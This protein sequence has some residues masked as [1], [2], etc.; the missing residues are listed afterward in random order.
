MLVVSGILLLS[1][2]MLWSA[3]FIQNPSFES[4]YNEDFPHY[5]PVDSWVGGSGVN[6]DAGPFH[7]TGTPIPDRSRVGFKQ[8]SGDLSQDIAG[9]TA[10]KQYWIQFF[11]DARNCCGGTIDIVTKFP[12]A[13]TVLDRIAN[14]RPAILS[15]KP[16]YARSVPFVAASDSGT[17]TFTTTASGDATALFDGVTIVERDTN[18]IVV[19]NP[20]FEASGTLPALGQIASVAGW[21]GAGTFGVDA[22]AGGAGFA[23]N[24]AVPDQDLVAFIQ[25]PGSLG[26]TVA[27]LAV[28]KTYQVTVAYNAKSGTVPHF[29]IKVDDAVLFEEDVS[30]VGAANPYKL[31]T[32]SFVA[33]NILAQVAFEQTKDGADVLLL[34]DVRVVGEVQKPLPPLAID[35]N[36]TELAPGQKA[37]VTVTVPTELLA[38]KSATI[39]FQSPNPAVAMLVNADADGFVA[40]QYAQGGTNVQSFDVEAVGRGTVR[41]VVVDS[42]G[43]TV[44]NDVTVN[45]VT[46]FVR[47]PSFESSPAPA[48]LGYGS[49]LAWTTPASGAGLNTVAGPF[50]DNGVIPDRKQVAF[51]QN[52]GTISQ[53]IFGLSPGKKYWLQFYYNARNC[54][55]GTNGLTVRFDGKNLVTVPQITPV[56]EQNSYYF[57]HLELSPTNATGLLE[58]VATA[59]GDATLLLDA[60]TIVQRDAGEIVIKNPSFEAS[61][62]PAN[63]GY[64]QPDNIA[65]WDAGGVGRG[66]NINGAG[67]FTDNGLAS[68]QDLV[69]FLQGKTTLVSQNITGLNA[70]Q[71]YTLI[72]DVNARNCCVVEPSS[73]RASFD[74]TPLVEEEITPVG[75]GAPFITR[76][77]L[78]KPTASEGVLKFENTT[79]SG[80]HT[81]LLDNVRIVPGVIVPAP[82]LTPQVA[83]GNTIRI[84]WPTAATQFKLQTTASLP[85]NWTDVT[86]QIV[87]EGNDNVV[88][89]SVGT[90]GNKFYRLIGTP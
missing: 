37:T 22:A 54:C 46:A 16:Y 23:N 56:L 33:S 28:G 7:N 30:P 13:D 42:A 44:V 78:F 47:N 89:E 43:L 27:N 3:S 32:V 29:R 39:T 73:Y 81:I 60:I 88:T 55:G 61:G 9:L 5:G 48:G 4:N 90:T 51:I 12:D 34:D 86:T 74:D 77:V 80:D 2:S 67:P 17:L 83:A 6:E 57:Q 65:G 71:Q 69:L 68:D 40:L 18:N 36:F 26:Q 38:T 84:A 70:G 35:P 45:V 62:T 21:T 72:F 66:V 24:G 53:Q 79:A 87:V 25:G 11:Y 85:G 15:S 75:A 52:S 20:S 8:G 31:K 14:V 63:V 64:I 10:G 58:F 50:Q 19:I 82:K 59:S 76:N 1:T 49:I 41:I